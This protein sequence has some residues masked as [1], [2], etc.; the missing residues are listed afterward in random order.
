MAPVTYATPK[1][2]LPFFQHTLLRL[3]VGQLVHAGVRR[4]AINARH[5]AVEVDAFVTGE[6]S[7]AFP[8][9]EFFVSREDEVLGTGGALVQ[10]KAW[11]SEAPFWVLN[12]DAVFAQDL[13]EMAQAH[14]DAGHAA[15]LMVTR[16]PRYRGL[17]F[18][19]VSQSGALLERTPAARDEGVVFCGVHLNEPEIFDF[20]LPEG[21]CCVLRAGHLPWAAAGE[22]VRTF[23]TH[24]FWAD[25]GTPARYLEAHCEAMATGLDW[26]QRAGGVRGDARDQRS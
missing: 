26:L 14:G 16:S 25:V 5:L 18:L 9:V 22:K 19:R 24:G 4:I 17:R 15:T 12:S 2:L 20:L 10:L 11:L 1:P 3:S 8:S 13:S 6:L 7:R 23:E 21:E